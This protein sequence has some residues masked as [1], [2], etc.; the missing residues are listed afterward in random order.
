M[1]FPL[2]ETILAN[3]G[4]TNT[5]AFEKVYDNWI[6][7]GLIRE[8]LIKTHVTKARRPRSLDG[9]DTLVLPEEVGLK[10]SYEAPLGKCITLGSRQV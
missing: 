1:T 7:R 2:Q 4:E 5:Y 3:M 9:E 6:S 8:Y 10:S